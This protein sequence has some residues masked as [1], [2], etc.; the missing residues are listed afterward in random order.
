M[1]PTEPHVSGWKP[2]FLSADLQLEKQ[3]SLLSALVGDHVVAAWTVW[4]VDQD[5]W[6]ADLP[7]VLELKSGRQ[8]ELCW[9]KFDDLSVTWD[10]IDLAVTPKAWVDW[11]LEWRR[12]ENSPF[13]PIFGSPITEVAASRLLFR[14]ENVDHPDDVRA[15]WLTTGLWI[16]TQAGGLHVFNALDENG[17]SGNRPERDDAHDVRSL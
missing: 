8:M 12:E 4:M 14:T 13:G 2:D 7:V 3:A 5:E 15:T 16:G 17:V 6:F 9:E 1:T 10:T 11:P